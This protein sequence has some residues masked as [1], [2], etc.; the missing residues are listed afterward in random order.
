MGPCPPR[1]CLEAGPLPVMKR[2]QAQAALNTATVS[3]RRSFVQREP[4]SM[5]GSR[6]AHQESEPDVG[7][8]LPNGGR[9]HPALRV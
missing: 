1:C 4:S 5:S 8:S 7:R 2:I 3:N 6:A 9:D